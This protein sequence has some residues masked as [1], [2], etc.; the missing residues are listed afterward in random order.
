VIR[1]VSRQNAGSHV[2]R[3]YQMHR[4]RKEVFND[5][6]GWSVVVSD[7]LE[8]DEYDA[9]DAVY[10][11][12]ETAGRIVGSVR[13]LPTLGPYMMRDTFAG[14]LPEIAAPASAGLWEASRFGVARRAERSADGLAC[15]TYELLIG[16]LGLA[17]ANDVD[18]ILCVVDARME[19]VLR[20]AGWPMRRLCD[21]RPI[22]G[23][24][25]LAGRLE[26]SETLLQR[27][28]QRAAGQAARDAGAAR[29]A[30][31]RCAGGAAEPGRS[32]DRNTRGKESPMSNPFDNQDGS[33]LVLVNDDGAHSLWPA[34][35]APPAGWS[36]ALAQNSRA[37]CLQ[38]VREHW[39][40][41]RPRSL[42][43]SLADVAQP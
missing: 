20:R 43:R 24:I 6:L 42:V 9:L 38:Y 10:V 7:D 8:A 21:A 15:A 28:R 33:F 40:D 18:A 25:T 19:R 13:L 37:V 35:I 2:R 1:I 36:V 23:T 27:L 30:H 3:L 14:F 31:E 39:T 22:G 41:M 16:V 32:L 4:L 12:S 5:R 17:I 26:V 34:F 29:P 11:L